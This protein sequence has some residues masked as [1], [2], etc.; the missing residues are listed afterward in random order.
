MPDITCIIPSYNDPDR[1]KDAVSSALEQASVKVLVQIVDDSSDDAVKKEISAMFKLD[2]RVDIF[3][4][5]QNKGQSLARNIG[6][7][8]ARTEFIAFLDQ[9]DRVAPG[10]Y[11][12]GIDCLRSRIGLA[13]IC[14]KALLV[15]LPEHLKEFGLKSQ[16]AQD[17]SHV[18]INNFVFRRAPFMA[19]GGFPLGDAWRT[20]W[21]GEDA[22]FRQAVYRYWNAGQVDLPAL[23][24]TVKKAGTTARFLETKL[25]G[26]DFKCLDSDFENSRESYFSYVSQ[27]ANEIKNTLI[28]DRVPPIQVGP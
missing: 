4:M 15:D 12:S 23:L 2:S 3:F 11:A 13:A 7:T 8:L 16:V 22:A 1:L 24:H 21:A 5:P 17:L 28:I 20:A 25:F 9:D 14:G 6:G 26:A 18:F 19:S 27:F 10:W